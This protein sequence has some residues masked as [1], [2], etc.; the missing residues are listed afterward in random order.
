MSCIRN[1]GV[2]VKLRKGPQQISHV[3]IVESGIL[4]SCKG[5]SL[6]SSH[7]AAGESHLTLSC[8]EKLRVPLQLPQDL[9]VPI[10]FQQGSQASSCVEALNST[11]LSCYK[12]VVRPPVELRRAFRTFLGV[13]HGNQ[14]SLRVVR[15]NWGFH[16]SH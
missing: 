2:P 15:G 10:E 11:S 12:R 4:S 16:S 3:A 9:R 14:T 13:Q 7:I 5:A 1:L 6:N 8:G